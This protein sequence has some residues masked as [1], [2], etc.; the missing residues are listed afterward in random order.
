MTRANTDTFLHDFPRTSTVFIDKVCLQMEPCD[1]LVFNL[2]R[3]WL[4]RGKLMMAPIT[5]WRFEA[6]LAAF[7]QLHFDSAPEK[8]TQVFMMESL[9][10]WQTGF[11]INHFVTTLL[12]MWCLCSLEFI[13]KSTSP[14]ARVGGHVCSSHSPSAVRRG[15][16][17]RPRVGKQLAPSPEEKP[18]LVLRPERSAC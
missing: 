8:H 15:P 1:P 5:V 4:P 16:R 14:P 18:H 3:M 6:S 10:K 11:P 12:H 17:W 7:L 9:W 13:N 2:V